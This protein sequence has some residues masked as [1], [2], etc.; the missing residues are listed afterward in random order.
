MK[1]NAILKSRCE[2]GEVLTAEISEC[3]IRGDPGC[4][5]SSGSVYLAGDG[6]SGAKWKAALTSS[7][8]QFLRTKSDHLPRKHNVPDDRVAER[9]I[10]TGGFSNQEVIFLFQSEFLFRDDLRGRCSEGAG[11]LFSP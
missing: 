1:S 7:L 2:V 3:E 4:R 11:G 6:S 10:L 9:S 5:R 8:V